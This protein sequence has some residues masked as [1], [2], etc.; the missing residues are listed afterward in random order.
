MSR[1][2]KIG[3]NYFPLD[4]DLFG[5]RKIQRLLEEYNSEGIATSTAILCDIYKP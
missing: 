3:L 1:P 5:N 2:V 4:S